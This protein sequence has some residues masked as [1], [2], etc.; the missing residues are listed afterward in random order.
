MGFAKS[1][2]EQEQNQGFYFVGDKY[3][4][5]DC[6]GNHAIRKFIDNNAEAQ[7]CSYCGSSSSQPI[8]AHID[9]VMA[10]ILEGIE[11]E[12]G[13]PD[14]EGVLYE[15]AEGG[16]QGRVI[17]SYD[18]IV[19]E[20]WDELEISS[21]SL[22][23]DIMNSLRGRQ[24]C[25]RNFWTLRPEEALSFSWEQ[26]VERVKYHTRYVFFRVD[27][28]DVSWDRDTIPPSKMLDELGR[29]ASELDLIKVLEPGTKIW[30]ARIHDKN[31]SFNTAKELG[32]VRLDDAKHSNRMSPAG[33][34]MFYG[35]FD[36]LTALKETAEWREQEYTIATIAP[37]RTLRQMRVLN[38][39]GLPKVPSLFDESKREL[40][41]SLE[42][43][44]SFRNDISKP[45]IKEEREHIE[46]VPTQIVTEYFRHM[47]R[48]TEGNMLTGILYPSARNCGGIACVLFVDN[49]DC[50][51]T[52]DEAQ[53][54]R[55]RGKQKYLF[56]EKNQI[57]RVA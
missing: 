29:I 18:L 5:A 11:F 28:S 13:D 50:C 30:R 44:Y 40:R 53:A 16:Y 55:E 6:F 32:T 2:W 47:Y 45:I 10:F 1:L 23:E 54:D 17:D 27:G 7:T 36:E 52:L 4:C 19:D 3:V 34:P 46:Y 21:D 41:P 9:K 26:F 49:E 42:F 57:K 33:I 56:L 48:D 51:D 15:T 22:R 24:W 8:A 25:Q 20:I 43:L 14:N 12:W 35:A 38:L 39:E 37:W 31:E